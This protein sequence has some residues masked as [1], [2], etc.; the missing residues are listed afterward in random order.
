MKTK[1]LALTLFLG[2]GMT[3]AFLGLLAAGSMTLVHADTYTVINTNASG[4][5]SLRQAI[6]DANANPGHDMIDFGVSG[7][8]VLTDALPVINDDLTISGPGV[9]QLAVSGDNQFRVFEID[10]SAAVTMTGLTVRDGRSEKGAGIYNEG[11]LLLNDMIVDSNVATSTTDSAYGGG[12][13]NQGAMTLTA[14]I[15]SDN[16]IKTTNGGFGANGGGICNYYEGTLVISDVLVAGNIVTS[17]TGSAFGGGIYNRGVMTLTAAT[18]SDNGATTVINGSSASGGGIYNYSGGTSLLSDMIVDSNIVTSTTGFAS[19]GGIYNGGTLALTA[20]IVSN[21]VATTTA[22]S[23][24]AQG[25]GICSSSGALTLIATTVSSN[26]SYGPSGQGGGIYSRWND[27]YVD[28]SHIVNNSTSQAGGGISILNSSNSILTGT[29][30]VRNSSRSN[31]GGIYVFRSDVVLLTNT[32]IYRNSA[33]SGSGGGAYVNWDSSVLHVSGGEIHDNLASYGGGGVYVSMGSLVLMGTHVYNNDSGS[34]YKGGGVNANDGSV[35]LVDARVYS[36][37]A[38]YGGGMYVYDGSTTLS[39]TQVVSN[40]AFYDGG[41]VFVDNSNVTL[42]GGRIA[43][44]D[45]PD[46]SGV[47]QDGGAI[48]PATALTVTGDVYQVGGIFAGSSHDL[49]IEGSLRQA[50]GDFYAPD[51]PNDFALTGPFTHTG[52]TYHQTQVVTGS[53]D[54]GFPKAG[55]VILNANNL[56]LNSTEV[57][58]TAGA[59]CTGVTAG[60]A[61]EHCY[62]ITPTN[63]SGGTLVTGRDAIITF[64]YIDSEVPGGQACAAMEAYHWDS[65][66]NNILTRDGSYGSDGRMCGADPLSIKVTD[67]MTFSPFVLRGLVVP[68]ITVLP[69]ALLFGD[70]DVGAGATVSRTV[71]ITNDGTANLNISSVSLTGTDDG[72]FVI[73]S[74]TGESILTPGDTRTVQVSF[75]P[76]TTG[77]K[78]ANLSVASDDGDEATVD[79]ALTGTGTEGANVAPVADGGGNQSVNVGEVVTLDGSGSNDPDGDVPL[80]YSWA[81]DGGPSV[82]FT[83]NLSITTFTAPTSTTVLTF[84]RSVTDALGLPSAPVTVITTVSEGSANVAPVADGGGNQSVT[85]GEVVTL[86]GSGSSD[87]DGNLPLTYSWAQDGGPAVTFTPNLS[88]TTF[89]APTSTTVLTFTLTVTDALGLPSTPDTVVITVS[90][91]DFYIY[92]PVVLRN[93]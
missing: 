8:I 50:G 27:L 46:G 20:T 39:G 89:T 57:A 17:T 22:S 18:V 88:I 35:T 92:L 52:G 91:N 13:Y 19:G 48:T 70:Q 53:S 63:S 12:I 93:Q 45:A 83:P 37:L 21:N 82:T 62:V 47:Y 84:T 11:M 43:D 28:T 42:N 49:R 75:D 60:D 29:H 23:R 38:S 73:E 81:Q 76:T 24:A 36:N 78:S 74:D 80:T 41:G 69:S 40:S 72:E 86:D 71:I 25:G 3:L 9:E 90:E 2:L 87:P 16:V 34:G 15:V 79:V 4:P 59:D 5:D 68:E 6:I 77:A 65:T 54:V 58:I 30:L 85:V 33:S 67:V 14:A 32:H 61:V 66:W 55:G 1:R 56:D 26:T 44:N 10:G 7:A 31:A 64:Y 51:A